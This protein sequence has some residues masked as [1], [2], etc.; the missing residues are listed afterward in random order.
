MVG[1]GRV[2]PASPAG[3]TPPMTIDA[4]RRR[5][6]LGAVGPPVGLPH[7]AGV[8]LATAVDPAR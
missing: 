1:H 6:T 2:W 5:A 4:E 3:R 7:W 8:R